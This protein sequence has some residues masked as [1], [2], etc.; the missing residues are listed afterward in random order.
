[1][2]VSQTIGTTESVWLEASLRKQVS[3]RLLSGTKEG[4]THVAPSFWL[5]TDRPRFPII[6]A[7]STTGRNSGGPT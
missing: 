4:E 3:L 2:Q 7:H 6:P 5:E 1:M